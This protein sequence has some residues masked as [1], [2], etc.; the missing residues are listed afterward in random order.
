MTA[1][2]GVAACNI[3]GVTL[4]S[5]AGLGLAEAPVDKL[6]AVLLKDVRKAKNKIRW[7][8]AQVLIIDEVSM[9]AGDF[10][11]KLDKVGR[12][13]R[14]NDAPFGGIQLILAGDVRSLQGLQPLFVCLT[15]SSYTVSSAATREAA[16]VVL[17]DE[18]LEGCHH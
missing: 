16:A 6:V 9:L 18:H 15:C 1:S 3:S 5:W 17:R 2:T 7:L 12:Q 13:V 11:E 10:F 8:D 4:H 14:N